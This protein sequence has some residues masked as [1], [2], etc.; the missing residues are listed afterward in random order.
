M[1]KSEFVSELYFCSSEVKN[2]LMTTRVLLEPGSGWF[3]WN[4][5]ARALSGPDFK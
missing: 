4:V 2:D 3:C 1:E 5:S